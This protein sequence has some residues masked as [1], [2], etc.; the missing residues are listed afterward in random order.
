MNYTVTYKIPSIFIIN[1]LNTTNSHYTYRYNNSKIELK[2]NI[3]NINIYEYLNTDNSKNTIYYNYRYLKDRKNYKEY[4]S[5]KDNTYIYKN[6]YENNE[7]A[8]MIYPLDKNHIFIVTISTMNATIPIEL[9]NNI[10]LINYKE[11]S[12]NINK[13]IKNN[14]LVSYLKILSADKEKVNQIK[15]VLPTTYKEIDKGN[16]MY[17]IRYFKNKTINLKYDIINNVDSSIKNIKSNYN[18]YSK[19]GKTY[20][21][22]KSK[23]KD[24]IL[25]E[26]SYTTKN[27]K[28]YTNI[29]YR[30]IDK[31]YIKIEIEN[32]DRIN[33]NL[34]E[35][36]TNISNE[37]KDYKG[38]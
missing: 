9:V 32:I 1:E 6:S 34:L 20:L 33:N 22:K 23:Y 38:E 21:N 4:L 16:N 19:Y 27:N 14:K 12:S 8:E 15:I 11:Y 17:R 26:G 35:E 37:I 28:I 18:V 29:L 5:N 3:K 10:K 13:I 36:V 2:S 31:L 30:Q 7:N 25:Y 24:Y